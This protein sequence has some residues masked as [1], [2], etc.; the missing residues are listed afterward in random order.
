MTEVLIRI[1]SIE[2]TFNVRKLSS[3][4]EILKIKA[5]S[6]SGIQIK[7]GSSSRNKQIY[8]NY[9]LS[10]IGEI[11][12]SWLSGNWK[13]IYLSL[14]H[15]LTL[16]S[17]ELFEKTEGI[18]IILIK[19]LKNIQNFNANIKE[20]LENKNKMALQRMLFQEFIHKVELKICVTNLNS[21]KGYIVTS[22]NKSQ[23]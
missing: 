20:C 21:R 18:K 17:N 10:L 7:D 11:D 22:L 4:T 9:L 5:K 23:S 16:K 1:D 15:E 19:G 3:F 8:I 6:L 13:K 12:N 2:S 14:K